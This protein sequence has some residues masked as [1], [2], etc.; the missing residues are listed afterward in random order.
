[1]QSLA[2]S[3]FMLKL[4]SLKL[5]LACLLY[6]LVSVAL[7]YLTASDSYQQRSLAPWFLVPP[8]SLLSLN[9]IAAIITN[10]SFRAQPALLLFHLSLLAIALLIGV[11]HLTNMKGWTEVVAGG[12]YEGSVNEP[13]AG[14]LHPWHIRQ[15]RFI[16]EGFEIDYAAGPSR[17][18]TAN[19]VRWQD[20]EGQEQSAV[21]G[22]QIPLQ[23]QGYRFYTSF[24]KGFAPKFLWRDSEGRV[25]SGAVHLPAWPEH[26]FNQAAEWTPAGARQSLWIQ[27]EFEDPILLADR[28]ST[29]RAP[30]EYQ[31]ILRIGSERHLMH[32]GDS[33]AL[34][35]GTLVF[36]GLTTWMGY[37]IFYDP[38]R[39]WLLAACLLAVMSI[40]GHFWLRFSARS[41][42]V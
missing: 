40:A 26:G 22:D 20:E 41:W 21:I 7:A 37:S 23:L 25:S 4:A 16:N 31:L 34:E 3:P 10:P 35:E 12:V 29:F 32:A 24:N 5:T 13:R 8:L 14:L 15:L 39:Y 42:Q 28:A 33:L 9:L 2:R 1:M 36:Q 18:H 6:L 38:S 27:L 30:A 19:R 17:R 11:G